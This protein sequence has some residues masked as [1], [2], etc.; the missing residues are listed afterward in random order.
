MR[1]L[2]ISSFN[3]DNLE[4]VI[5][6]GFPILQVEELRPEEGN[7]LWEPLGFE[8]MVRCTTLTQYILFPSCYLQA[9]CECLG[10]QGCI[11]RPTLEGFLVTPNWE[12]LGEAQ[13]SR[14]GRETEG[15]GD[16][17]GEHEQRR[18]SVDVPTALSLPQLQG[19][20][21]ANGSPNSSVL[22]PMPSGSWVQRPSLLAS[23]EHSSEGSPQLQSVPW[24]RPGPR[25]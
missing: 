24:D 7:G 18:G 3:A 20:V 25:V 10:Q 16:G 6:T 19:L 21:G 22:G 5:I 1:V 14:D 13:A 15:E 4:A 11:R 9:P 2:L 17:E 23:V 8:L 12:T